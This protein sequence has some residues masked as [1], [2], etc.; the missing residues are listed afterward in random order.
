D[1]LGKQRRQPVVT[2]SRSRIG[3]YERLEGSEP[4]QNMRRWTIKELLTSQELLA[5][6]QAMRHCV[7]SYTQE[8]AKRRTTIWS[9][10]VENEEGQRRVLTIEVDPKTRTICQVRGKRNR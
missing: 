6:G 1:E 8:C 10:R 2:W 9:L 5:E 3:E 4:L 7:A